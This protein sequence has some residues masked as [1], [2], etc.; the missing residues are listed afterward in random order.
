MYRKT[1][2]LLSLALLSSMLLINVSYAQDTEP[3]TGS[4]TIDNGA[5]Y[6]RSNTVVLTLTYSDG[7][8]SG[9]DKVRYTNAQEW[10]TEPWEDPVSVRDWNLTSGDG[11]KYVSYEIRDKVGLRKTVFDSIIV[12]TAPPTGKLSINDGAST[13]TSRSVTLKLTFSDAGS[14]VDMVRYTNNNVWGN[15]PWETPA[16]TKAWVLSEG[17]G[18]K[19]VSAEIRDKSGLKQTYYDSITLN[20][21]SVATPVF[22]PASGTYSSVQTVTVSCSTEGATIR[23]TTDGSEPTTTSTTY[24]SPITIDA[25]TTVK[26]K[27][28]KD[29][30]TDS[31]TATATYTVNLPGS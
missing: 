5:Y 26:A 17:E 8:G 12:D 31:D 11:A 16:P 6:T 9:V 28:F 23:Y 21:G 4:I 10:T 2:L 18:V 27:A 25:T 7:D 24:A 3:P 15:E 22:S 30:M 19:Y 13:T 20:Y 29:G 1:M 14:G